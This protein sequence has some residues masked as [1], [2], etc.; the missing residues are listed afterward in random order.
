MDVEQYSLDLSNECYKDLDASF[1]M[2]THFINYLCDCILMFF[3]RLYVR[4]N[5]VFILTVIITAII[6]LASSFTS[7]SC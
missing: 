5:Y 4:E 1:D 6:I 3:T 2:S 7:L